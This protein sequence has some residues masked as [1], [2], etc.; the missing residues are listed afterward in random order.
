MSKR[1]FGAMDPAKRREI[2]AR[3]GK[4]SQASGKGHRFTVEEAKEAGR[5]GGAKHSKEHMAEIGRLGGK[6]KKP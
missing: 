3:G 6:A 1:G 5:L 4:A 2:A